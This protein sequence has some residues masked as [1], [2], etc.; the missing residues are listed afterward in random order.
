MDN[1]KIKKNVWM[2]PAIND[3]KNSYRRIVFA[4]NKRNCIENISRKKNMFVHCVSL[5]ETTNVSKYCGTISY[6]KLI[7]TTM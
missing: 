5:A 1:K 2:I 6:R 4:M 7:K 3:V